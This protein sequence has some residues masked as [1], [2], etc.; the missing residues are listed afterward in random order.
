MRIGF[1]ANPGKPAAVR[2]AGRTIQRIGDRAEVVVAAETASALG[3]PGGVALERLDADVLLAFGGD[4]TFL[5]TLGRCGVPL[6]A[7]HAGTVGFLA[8]LDGERPEEL[9][10]AL[11]RVL[12]GR[13]F[14]ED[15]MK[16][17]AEID[18]APL[19]DAVNELVVHTGQVAKMR[20]FEV[21]IDEE[22]IGQI[23]ADGI[24]LATPT[25]ST[26]Y[27]LSAQGPILE[28]TVEAIVVAA[29]AP[30]HAPPRAVVI[31]P[32]RTVSIRPT[33]PGKDAVVVVDGQSDHPLSAGATVR[34]Y[35]SSRKASFV[36]FSSR[37]FQRLQGKRILPWQDDPAGRGPEGRVDVPSAA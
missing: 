15:R 22:R 5:Y 7:I 18:G 36:R 9:E 25:G 33:A 35:R 24:I 29:L 3:R 11:D 19:P 17:A 27:A 1:T 30:F 6:L 37:F 16:L 13:Y 31:D 2:L 21:R 4:G 28:P 20:P 14:V 34:A 26:S 10:A 23:R 32:L 8:E 12:E